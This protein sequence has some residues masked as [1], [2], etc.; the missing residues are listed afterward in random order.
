MKFKE[1][2]EVI[3]HSL[4]EQ[5]PGEFRA[6]IKGISAEWEHVIFY[7]VEFKDR[8]ISLE[9]YPYSHGCIVGSCIRKV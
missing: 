6:I 8:F 2:D 5:T 1:G 7:I 4:G 3:I 9:D